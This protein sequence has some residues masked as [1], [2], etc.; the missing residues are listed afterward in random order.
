MCLG[1]IQNISN[2]LMLNQTIIHNIFS[3][4]IEE[5]WENISKSKGGQIIFI[6][7][8]CKFGRV[9]ICNNNW[10]CTRENQ[11]SLVKIIGLN[12]LKIENKTF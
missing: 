12:L 9:V 1:S 11:L 4:K 5:I 8:K 2:I 7:N 10:R 6:D 3:N